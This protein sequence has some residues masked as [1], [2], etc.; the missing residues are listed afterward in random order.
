MIKSKIN[1]S[2]AQRAIFFIIADITL[3]IVSFFMSFYIRFEFNISFYKTYSHTILYTLPF[4]VVV[5]IMFLHVLNVYRMSWRYISLRDV[6]K[7][8]SALLL[9]E[10]LLIVLFYY[11]NI[12]T[13]LT[14][15]STILL[16]PRSI[17]AID[18]IITVMLI[19]SLRMLK[20]L[21]VEQTIFLKNRNEF[22]TVIIGAGNT[23]DMVIRDISRQKESKFKVICFLDDDINKIHSYIHG[24][25]VFGNTKK[26]SQIKNNYNVKYVIVA[27]QN[28]H[29]KNLKEIYDTCRKSGVNTIKIVPKFYDTENLKVTT[30]SLEDIKIED[31]IGRQVVKI[32]YKEIKTSLFDKNILITG[33]CGSIGSE[34][35]KQIS[36]FNPAKI[37]LFDIDETAMHNIELNVKKNNSHLNEY[38]VIGDIRDKQRL[39]QVF[40]YYKP[41][42][43]FH[44]AAYKHV[45]MMEH[46]P[47]EAVKVNIF[48]THNVALT[49]IKF[50]VEKFIIISTDKAIN[51]NSVMGSTKHIAEKI[52]KTLNG[53]TKFISV[54]FGNVLGSRGSML[55][56]FLEQLK[57][58][59]PLTVTHKDMKRYFMTISEAVSLVLQASIIGNGG[60][61][62]LLDMG[63][64]V[65]I[66]Y[67]AEELIKLQGLEPYRDV[68]IQIT[69]IRP[70]EKLFEELFTTNEDVIASKHERIF[71]VREDS[72]IPYSE[73]EKI[74]ND[75]QYKLN[76]ISYQNNDLIKKYLKDIVLRWHQNHQIHRCECVTEKANQKGIMMTK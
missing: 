34:I 37:I 3:I 24:I 47:S 10:S 23:G 19:C 68:D 5:K 63:D 39:E 69:G 42:I 13:Y 66:L 28:L 76:N 64:P 71:I 73:I 7:L 58:G 56:L 15:E 17:V 12:L 54:R 65:S 72:V 1:F 33:A 25:K 57:E 6:S 27:I 60:D 59:G 61:V 44:S 18:C 26:L 2:E 67:I 50:G 75:I 8:T 52:C 46:N 53:S 55:P 29:R 9:S 45:P 14:S 35:V 48:G 31:I 38:F 16:L 4:F 22:N 20:R 41:H 43:V 32:D 40:S 70:G 62:M 74:L 11:I 51:P 49:S 21:Y 30:L 36:T